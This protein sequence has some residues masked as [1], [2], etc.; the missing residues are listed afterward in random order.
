MDL[1]DILVFAK[2]VEA[3]SFIGASRSLGMPKSTVSRKVSA[4]EENLGARLLQRSTRKLSLSTSA[5]PST[6][7]PSGS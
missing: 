2:V 3:G 6:N 4:L 1:N 5:R 7:A